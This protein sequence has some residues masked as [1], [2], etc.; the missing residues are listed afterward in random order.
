MLSLA[1]AAGVLEVGLSVLT[2]GV[3]G[4]AIIWFLSGLLADL[5]CFKQQCFSCVHYFDIV[6]I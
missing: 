2:E 4:L 1:A 5:Q 3:E 6:L